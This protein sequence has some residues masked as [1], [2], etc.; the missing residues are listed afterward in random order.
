[1]E[2]AGTQPCAV[3]GAERQIIHREWVPRGYEVQSLQCPGCQ[4]VMRMVRKRLSRRGAR[5]C[6][7]LGP[8]LSA[9]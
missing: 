4:T 1:M 9:Q 2:V 8:P 7:R 5:R 6:R 3:C